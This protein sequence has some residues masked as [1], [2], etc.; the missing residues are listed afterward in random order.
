MVAIVAFPQY[1]QSDVD[2]CKSTT[3]DHEYA[4]C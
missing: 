2:F 1:V 4:G 3:L